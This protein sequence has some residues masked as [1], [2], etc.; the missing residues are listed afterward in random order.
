MSFASLKGPG[1]HTSIDGLK[2][3]NERRVIRIY[4]MERPVEA[5]KGYKKNFGEAGEVGLKVGLVGMLTGLGIGLAMLV[6]GLNVGVAGALIGEAALVTGGTY[7]VVGGT[8]GL[9]GAGGEVF[10]D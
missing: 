9:I 10:V 7:G 8:V 4:L 5:A 3:W 1:G 2:S 6:P